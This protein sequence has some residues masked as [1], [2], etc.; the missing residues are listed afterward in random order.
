MLENN[1]FAEINVHRVLS[2]I[3]ELPELPDGIRLDVYILFSNDGNTVT[4]EAWLRPSNHKAT[5]FL[6]DINSFADDGQTESEIED[7]LLSYYNNSETFLKSVRAVLDEH[8]GYFDIK[9]E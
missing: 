7:R 8:Y 9:E 6:A 4:S 3:I 1:E 5:M 2:L